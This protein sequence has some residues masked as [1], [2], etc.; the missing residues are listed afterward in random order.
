MR[1]CITCG[2]PFEGDHVS[3]IGL[4]LPDGPVCKFDVQDGK[5]KSSKEI[6]DGG[7]LFFAA[8]VTQGDN[9][10]AE[11]LTRKNM[12]SLIYWQHH[13]FAELEGVEATDEEFAEAMM[14]L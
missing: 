2:M 3:D 5:L 8:E 12:K 11:K 10:L 13:P 6:F 14:K 9:I 4:E 7:V 1:S